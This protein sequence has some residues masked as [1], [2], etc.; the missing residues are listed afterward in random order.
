LRS[1]GTGPGRSRDPP[2]YVASLRPARLTG[3]PGPRRSVADGP[4]GR[5]AGAPYRR[6]PRARTRAP[7]RSGPALHGPR[8]LQSKDWRA[9]NYL[10]AVFSTFFSRISTFFITTSRIGRITARAPPAP[11]VGRF[12]IAL[13]VSSP[14]VTRAKTV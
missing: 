11:A 3:A 8:F 12:V 6:R 13:T 9:G 10:P 5:G 14:A 7:P 1:P 4:G 2:L